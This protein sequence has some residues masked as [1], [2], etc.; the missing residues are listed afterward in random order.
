MGY[1]G[2]KRLED[3]CTPGW[4]G[5]AILVAIVIVTEGLLAGLFSLAVCLVASSWYWTIR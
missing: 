3:F 2:P 5:V 4:F 1:E